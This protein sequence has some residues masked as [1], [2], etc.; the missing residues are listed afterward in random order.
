MNLFTF[1]GRGGA[2]EGERGQD[3]AE[4]TVVL[5]IGISWNSRVT[6]RTLKVIDIGTAA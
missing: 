1:G 3:R 6:W 5:V 4:T 2:G